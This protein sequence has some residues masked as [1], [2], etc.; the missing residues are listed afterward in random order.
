MSNLPTWAPLAFLAVGVLMVLGF[1]WY[2]LYGGEDEEDE[3]QG[4]GLG[5]DDDTLATTA[6]GM[7]ATLLTTA[8]EFRSTG[9]KSRMIAL[10]ESLERS[11]DSRETGIKLSSQDRMKMPWYLL[12]GADG[13]GKKTLLANTGLSLPF[14]PPL[15][16]D[17]QR[18]DAGKWWLFDQAV[19]LE[20][21][22][23]SPGTTAGAQTLPPGQT[24]ADTSIGWN[25]L[26]HMLRRERPDSPLNG[27][28]VTISCADLISAR[29]SPER[30]EEQADRIRTF[31]ERT[32][33]F[34]GARLPIHVLVTKCDAMPGFRSFAEALPEKRRNDI[35]GWANDADP[36]ARFE[37]TWVDTGFTRLQGELMK[38]RDE[39]LA[40]QETVTDSVGVFIFDSEFGDLQ[41]PLKAF[42]ARL[43]P[44]G[45]RRPSLFFRGFYFT[46]DTFENGASINEKTLN[47]QK[48]RKTMQLSA[49][50]AGAP[51]NLVFLKSL[52]SEKI[53]KEAGL[54]RP[55]ARFRLSRDRRVVAAQAA[56]II[57]AMVG[58]FGLYT[59][60][61]GYR[62]DQEVVRAGLKADADALMR[63]LSG[64][65]IDLDDIRHGDRL[66]EAS[67]VDRRAR[68]AAVIE[69]VAQMR[70][71]PNMKVRSAFIP[72]SWFSPLPKEIQESMMAGIQSLVLPVVRQRLQE[73][74][75]RLLGT[76]A[77]ADT[78][79]PNEL[80]AS[81]PKTLTTY[82]EDVRVLSRNITRY[83]SLADSASGS[84]KE[85]SALLDYLFG[86]QIGEDTTL[87][88]QD[89]E[90]ALRLASAPKITLTPAMAQTV[91]RRSMAMV[92][93]VAV[94]SARQLAPPARGVATNPA[95]DLDALRGLAELVELIDPRKGIIASVSDSA[96]LG[97][98]LARQVDDS[99]RAALDRAAA[100]IA[101]DTLSQQNAGNRLRT[102]IGNLFQ[103]RLMARNE[104]RRIA[105]EMR[106]NERMRW[107]IGSLELALGLQ[108]EFLQALV[109]VGDAFP[110]Q[111]SDRMRRALEVQLRARALDVAASSQRFTTLEATANPLTEA[112]A[113]GQNLKDATD[114]I[115]R[116]SAFLDSL[117]AGSEG[118]KL[119]SAGTRQ[120][121][122]A[123]AMAYSQFEILHA[124]YA[125]R[126]DKIAVWQGI[127][128]LNFVA[129]DVVD[130]TRRDAAGYQHAADMQALV[131]AV[132]EPIRFLRVRA[133]P[134]SI[135]ATRLLGEWELIASQVQRQQRG[136]AASSM[137]QLYRYVRENMSM[138]ELA[139][140][141]EAATGMDSTPHNNDPFIKRR[142]QFQAALVSR[143]GTGGG[144]EALQ[145]YN[146][147]RTLFTQRLA[148][149]YPFAD[150]TYAVGGEADPAAVREFFRQL[151]EFMVF[152]DIAL[153]SH[154]TLSQTARSAITWVENVNRVRPFVMPFVAEGAGRSVP[155]YSLLVS[156]SSSM[157]SMPSALFELQIA[158]RLNSVE[159]TPLEH[160][161]RA[162][163]SVKVIITPF[164]T[165]RSRPLFAVAGTWGA[166]RLAQAAPAGVSVR[167]FDPDTKIELMLP[168]FPATAPDLAAPPRAAPT[169]AAQAGALVAPQP[170]ARVPSA[171]ATA[172]A[173]GVKSASTKTSVKTAPGQTK[174][175]APAR[176]SKSKTPTKS[177]RST[178]S[179]K[180]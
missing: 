82:L 29:N 166:L 63:V 70:D 34:L 127:Y 61:N 129:L 102:V 179:T 32:R 95:Q 56:A 18:K 133:Q 3:S 33:K 159:E 51:H 169:Q 27:I 136:D 26:L 157:D 108:G 85:L 92:N 98:R 128:P 77:T 78:L 161:W 91:L 141:T 100:F 31:L 12:V 174:A 170:P 69:M 17:S 43:M 105:G 90:D 142:R 89:F 41:E 59:S 20:A 125:P 152:A 149:R 46:G 154:P 165:S 97:V 110:G 71:V 86:E 68:D 176:G 22:A 75:D 155:A 147:L 114:R 13:S 50:I 45:E 131:D 44:I 132:L 24:V 180:R 123:L 40:A 143:C 30:M 83:N 8:E 76:R 52:F 15:E 9:R 93:E 35:F 118:R 62:R 47:E 148:G 134:D 16:V 94:A 172:P 48:G 42:V 163:D 28:I 137:A 65:A 138:Y 145:S 23:A 2:M 115:M 130:T 144:A 119:I 106:P 135:R 140:C 87:A 153:R 84:V 11:L 6:P 39:V 99:V 81:D 4:R 1:G 49:E 80:D 126:T 167:F 121:E 175:K 66:G 139:R 146:R 116:L 109:T 101:K 58:G 36:E 7:D 25:T 96:I 38:L 79:V 120:A 117:K 150:S 103:Y 21:P 19:V 158:E 73:R 124:K 122:N 10:K 5:L 54:A 74:A 162:G 112:K 151:D 177:A 171:G 104:G 113:A 53:F 60:I 88:R 64:L 168:V 164:D 55:T 111:P 160:F 156:R 67:P 178:K 72:S 37:P 107:D 173:A 14:G 57:L